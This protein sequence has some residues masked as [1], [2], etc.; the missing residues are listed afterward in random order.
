MMRKLASAFISAFIILVISV[1]VMLLLDVKPGHAATV[2]N[3]F[4]GDS[5]KLVD[6]RE[7]I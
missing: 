5:V 1:A 2:E 3:D 6:V 7:A 4:N